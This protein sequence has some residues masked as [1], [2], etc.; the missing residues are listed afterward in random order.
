MKKYISSVIFGTL[1]V[2]AGFALCFVYLVIPQG[3]TVDR[4]REPQQAMAQF[5]KLALHHDERGAYFT[6]AGM[7]RHE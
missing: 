7:V 2:G 1:G 5:S 6:P 3:E 4:G